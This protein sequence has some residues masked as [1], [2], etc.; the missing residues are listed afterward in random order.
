MLCTYVSRNPDDQ[1]SFRKMKIRKI[2]EMIIVQET[3][4]FS[5]EQHFSKNFNFNNIITMTLAETYTQQVKTYELRKAHKFNVGLLFLCV[6]NG[7]DTLLED[8]INSIASI[9]EETGLSYSITVLNNNHYPISMA[10]LEG[11]MKQNRDIRVIHN[12][13]VS[14][15]ELKNQAIR[16]IKTD[17]IV[18]FDPEKEYDISFADLLYS[19]VRR[20]EKR[21]LFSDIVIMPWDIIH[22]V[23]GWNDLNISEDI[24]L[25]S[26]IS[27][28]YG[29]LFYPT[30][31][32]ASMNRFLVYKPK[33]FQN[34]KEYM[35]MPSSRKISLMRDLIVG[36]NYS[37]KDLF[38]FSTG[39]SEMRISDKIIAMSA[40]IYSRVKSPKVRKKDKN[41]YVTFM[42]SMFES[43]I[44]KE[45]KRFDTFT[46]PLRISITE[47]ENRYLLARSEIWKKVRPSMR[48]FTDS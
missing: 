45:Y 42:E 21:M 35:N 18:M 40:Y 32:R 12:S 5:T 1:S 19:F 38:L 7:K 15:G 11:V 34:R 22:D 27:T 14:R 9:G 26:R 25:F 8:S 39:V 29:I 4:F 46:K 31:G 41:I 33:Q 36:C 13:R 37:M 3:E 23:G 17:Y 47:D 20:R 48:S 44:L 28:S 30:E 2:P 10:S 24:N 16:E 43:I 6:F